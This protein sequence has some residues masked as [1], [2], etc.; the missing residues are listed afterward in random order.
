[1]DT[2]EKNITARILKY[3][4]SLPGCRAMKRPGGL[5]QG[6]EPDITGCISG[7][8]I[9]LEVKRPGGNPTPRQAAALAKWQRVGAVVGVVHSVVEARTLIESHF[10]QGG[11]R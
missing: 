11:L 3:L 4:N 9:E 7:W 2:L 6:G 1:M 8:R 5:F 10:T